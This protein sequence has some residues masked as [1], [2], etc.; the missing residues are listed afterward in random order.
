MSTTTA[1]TTLSTSS[2]QAMAKPTKDHVEPAPSM[3][4]RAWATSP[5]V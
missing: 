3:T 5:E 4:K 1:K 2:Q